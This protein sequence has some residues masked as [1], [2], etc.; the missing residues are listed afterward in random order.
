MEYKDFVEFV[1]NSYYE[2][3]EKFNNHEIDDWEQVWFNQ[4]DE[5]L[6][7]DT[8]KNIAHIFY[9]DDDSIGDVAQ[10]IL[11]DLSQ[12]TLLRAVCFDPDGDTTVVVCIVKK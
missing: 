6:N 3:Q 8:E 12:E 1:E 10:G 2:T 7:T 5:K 11:D 4:L 9:A